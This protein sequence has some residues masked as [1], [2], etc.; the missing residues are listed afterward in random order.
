MLSHTF[1]V[2]HPILK[3]FDC[4]PLQ[5][6]TACS[7]G[8][9][10]QKAQE[11]LVTVGNEMI[12]METFRSLER[13]PHNVEFGQLANVAYAVCLVAETTNLKDSRLIGCYC[14]EN[15]PARSFRLN[16][17]GQLFYGDECLIPAMNS[18]Q[19]QLGDCEQ[20]LSK[21]W[22]YD[23][24]RLM[25]WVSILFV[26]S[27]LLSVMADSSDEKFE[28]KHYG[29]RYATPCEVCKIVA[30]ELENRFQATGKSHDVIETGYTFDSDQRTRK[31]YKAS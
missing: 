26:V 24:Q 23:G 14:A 5:L 18:N 17:E 1:Y 13:S 6:I 28:E 7:N 11:L 15:S 22:R 16:A 10:Q 30:L 25:M 9:Q 2:H 4:E 19:I 3:D 31:Q 8:Q 12:R 20:K 29:V 27:A 21:S